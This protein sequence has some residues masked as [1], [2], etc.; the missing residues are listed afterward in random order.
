MWLRW[1]DYLPLAAGSKPPTTAAL[2]T[3]V[4]NGSTANTLSGVVVIGNA[5]TAAQG[6]WQ[7]RALGSCLNVGVSLSAAFR[8][9]VLRSDVNQDG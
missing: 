9:N 7:H 5:A 8:V 4:A 1:R 3:E 6:K 2:S